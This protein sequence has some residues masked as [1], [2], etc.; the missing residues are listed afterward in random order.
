MKVVVV[1]TRGIPEIPGGVETHC[2]ELYPRLV[3][4]GDDVTVIRRSCYVTDGNRVPEYKGVKLLDLYAPRKKSLEAI[5]HTFL[6][7]LKAR[8][9]NPDILHVHAVGPS[10][11]VPFARL[12]GMKVV[13]TNHGPDYNRRKWGRLPKMA[14]RLGERMGSLFA[15]RVIVIS[16]TIAGIIKD[17]YGREKGVDLIYNGVNPPVLSE[18][19]GYIQSLG[20]SPRRYIVAVG[21]FVEEKGF[22]DLIKAFDK[23]DLPE[24][25]KLVLVGDTDH[26]DEYS[27]SLKNMARASGVVLTGYLRGEKMSQIMHNAMLFVLPSYHEGLPIALLEAMSYSLDVV[28][29][30]ISANIIENIDVDTDTFKVGNVDSLASV[31]A[32]KV[33]LGNT[34][35]QYDLK[36]FDWSNIAVATQDCYRKAIHGDEK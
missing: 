31:M 6:G 15:N 16:R 1:G 4:L 20:L 7:V 8:S 2:Q 18:S 35:R 28:V 5:V 10:L 13:M 11:M 19:V 25:V 17:C 14:L 33:S 30:D 24:D 21:R 9:L 36:P 29:S 26:P 23:A 12:L 32:R 34:P 3:A 22:H 27:E